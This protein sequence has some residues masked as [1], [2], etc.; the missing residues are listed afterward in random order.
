MLWARAFRTDPLSNPSKPRLVI[1]SQKFW[2]VGQTAR[3]RVIHRGPVAALVIRAIDQE[4]ANAGGAHLGEGELLTGH[5]GHGR[6]LSAAGGPHQTQV[7]RRGLSPSQPV[8]TVPGSRL[9]FRL[10]LRGP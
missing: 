5:G 2:K 3:G 4:T 9:L 1:F 7:I 6:Y 10:S 8:H